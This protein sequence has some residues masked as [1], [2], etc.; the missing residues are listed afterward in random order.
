[1]ASKVYFADARAERST[2]EKKTVQLFER[3]ELGELVSEGDLVALKLHFGEGQNP[4]TVRPSFVRAVADRVRDCG[5]KPFLTDAN[6]IYRGSRSNAVDHLETA[7][8][9]GYG[10]DAVGAPIIIGDGLKG[11]AFREVPFKGRYYDRVKLASE[12]LDADAMI[13]L[14][15]AKIHGMFGLGGALKNLG[16]GCGSR[17]GKQM[18]HAV[19]RPQ[20]NHEKCAA[21]RICGKWCPA[22]AISY[23]EKP[24]VIDAEKCIGCGECVAV[25]P[26]GA[27]GIDWGDAEG[28]QERTVE[29]AAAVTKELD[30]KVGHMSF[31]L[32][33]TPGC[34]C[35]RNPGLSFVPDVGILASRDPVAIDACAVDLINKA[36]AVPGS[37]VKEAT[38]PGEDKFKDICPDV[39]W[40][41]QLRYAEELGLGTREYDLVE[42]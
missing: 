30:G 17:G 37:V 3:A 32:R 42:V 22:D 35:M 27:I 29:F 34:D 33:I 13:C 5:G 7:V 20:S 19:V 1:M 23:P 40:S 28:C 4:N 24:A 41:V 8:R 15:H 6:T 10:F 31:A 25:C 38:A 21:C 39:D 16:M 14:T 12:I 36:P 18:M 26:Q 2:Q 11:R 9:H